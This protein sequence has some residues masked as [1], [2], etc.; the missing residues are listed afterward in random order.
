MNDPQ[1]SPRRTWFK[2]GEQVYSAISGFTPDPSE[3]VMMNPILMP[4]VLDPITFS[5]LSDGSI[6]Y[7]YEVENIT[8]PQLLP[9]GT[10]TI[11][12]AKQ[13]VF[14]LLLGNWTCMVSNTLGSATITYVISD[15]GK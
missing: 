4:G 14:E 1:P 8:S 6:A 13:Q 15:C 5:T 10:T 9:P 2:D 3:F 7:N 11:D 12:E